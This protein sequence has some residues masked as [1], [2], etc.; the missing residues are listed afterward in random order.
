MATLMIYAVP[1]DVVDQLKESAKRNRRSME[2]EV[3]VLLRQQYPS[4]PE[5]SCPSP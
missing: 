5:L 3:R 2:Q 4:R 1:E